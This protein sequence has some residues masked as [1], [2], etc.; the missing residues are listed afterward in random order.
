MAIEIRELVIKVKI[1]DSQNKSSDQI[2]VSKM[3]QSILKECQ[4][5]IKKQLKQSKER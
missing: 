1:E 5:E 4:R 3:K 2:D